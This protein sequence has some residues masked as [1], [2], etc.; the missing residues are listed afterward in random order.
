M[1]TTDRVTTEGGTYVEFSSAA[2]DYMFSVPLV[3]AVVLVVVALVRF[4]RTKHDTITA[5]LAMV[6]IVLVPILGPAAYLCVTRHT[7]PATA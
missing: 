6:L 7:V 2:Y 1:T 5:I 3:V 4:M